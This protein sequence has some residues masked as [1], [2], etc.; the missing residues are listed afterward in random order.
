MKKTLLYLSL[1]FVGFNLNAQTIDGSKIVCYF[2]FETTDFATTDQIQSPTSGIIATKSTLD[3]TDPILEA[4]ADTND[5]KFGNASA[6]LMRSS[7]II[8]VNTEK[9]FTTANSFTCAAWVK[10]KENVG[11]QHFVHQ[12][13]DANSNGRMFIDKKGGNGTAFG[14]FLTGVTTTELDEFGDPVAAV[15]DTWYHIAAILDRENNETRLYV[16]G[17]LEDTKV[18]QAEICAADVVLG[19]L[20]QQNGNFVDG[21]IDELLLTTEKL[22]Q[23]QI[24]NIMDNGV[25]GQILSNNDVVK[26]NNLIKVMISPNKVLSYDVPY[27]V[28]SSEIYS[29]TGQ[30]LLSLDDITKNE[31]NLST[32]SSGIYIL[33]LE[34]DSKFTTKKFVLK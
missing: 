1:I 2:P 24:M 12:L 25:A 5:K 3:L 34:S 28:D 7:Y 27:K 33:K 13:S 18:P 32:F 21:N 10:V 19:S 4:A 26:D 17:V 9:G 11:S 15:G 8:N 29:I 16:N 14:S 6:R 30:K 23:E 31:I 22:T 20:R